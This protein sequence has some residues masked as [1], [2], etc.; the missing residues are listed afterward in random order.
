MSNPSGLRKD[1]NP[2]ASALLGVAAIQIVVG[3]LGWSV[4]RD[5]F[6][7][8]DWIIMFSGAIYIALSVAARWIRLSAALIGATL[9]AAFLVLQAWRSTDLLMSGLIFKVPVVLL[10]L[11][12]VVS[13]LKRAL[14]LIHPRFK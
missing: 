10:L 7:W 2:T 11:V 8:L 14:P 4:Y 3:F 1:K 13:A 9:Y 12:A 6:G 5:S